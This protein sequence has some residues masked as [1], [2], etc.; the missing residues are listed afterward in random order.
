MSQS[1]TPCI[2]CLNGFR[3]YPGSKL[4]NVFYSAVNPL[5]FNYA[6]AMVQNYNTIIPTDPELLL[7]NEF[8]G[9]SCGKRIMG[10]IEFGAISL[11]VQT[12]PEYTWEIP[13]EWN[14]EDAATVPLIH[15]MVRT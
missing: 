7:G 15:T 12:D 14:L 11:Q 3:H 4:A 9:T 6:T 5:D 1:L 8:S 13:D 2:Y 10:L